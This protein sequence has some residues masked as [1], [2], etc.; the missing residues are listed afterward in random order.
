VTA[1]RTS[2]RVVDGGL[3]SVE[4]AACVPPNQPL[5]PAVRAASYPGSPAR[6]RAA[7][8]WADESAPVAIVAASNHRCAPVRLE[9]L[10]ERLRGYTTP[11]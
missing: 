6:G 8:R 2:F 9:D 11:I 1:Y 4:H 7:R 10:R 5:L 3:G